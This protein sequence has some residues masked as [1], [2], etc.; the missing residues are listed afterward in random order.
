MS[1]PWEADDDFV[2]YLNSGDR[3]THPL[4]P[5]VTTVRSAFRQELEIPLSLSPD[6][7]VALFSMYYTHSFGNAVLKS[8]THFHCEVG[9]LIPPA[10]YDSMRSVQLCRH[11]TIHSRRSSVARADSRTGSVCHTCFDGS[12]L[13]LRPNAPESTALGTVPPL[14]PNWIIFA[15]IWW[16][17]GW[18]RT[19]PYPFGY[20]KLH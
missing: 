16:R 17:A 19:I 10:T 11:P 7:Q 4:E 1:K 18:L 12:H 6:W 5:G 2:M 14:T 3:G 15:A 8:P 20:R 13:S 9:Y